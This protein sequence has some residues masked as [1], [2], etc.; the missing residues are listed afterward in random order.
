M[1]Y[2]SI[3]Q[4]LLVRCNRSQRATSQPPLINDSVI[5]I[6]KRLENLSRISEKNTK[7]GKFEKETKKLVRKTKQQNLF[8]EEYLEE[9]QV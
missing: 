3:H 7:K 9:K 4:L 5:V 6:P 8:K 2:F 1:F